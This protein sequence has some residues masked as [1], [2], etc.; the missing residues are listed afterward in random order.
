MMS[1]ETDQIEPIEQLE[2]IDDES[3]EPGS[4]GTYLEAVFTRE[5]TP[6]Q[7]VTIEVKTD[8]TVVEKPHKL[9]RVRIT[10][11]FIRR[12][13]IIKKRTEEFCK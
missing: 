5:Q 1:E 12:K 6:P 7:G 3:P 13:R 2:S 10:K 4:S 9:K 11:R 8:G